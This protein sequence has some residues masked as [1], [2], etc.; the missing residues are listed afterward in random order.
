MNSDSMITTDDESETTSHKNSSENFFS[1]NIKEDSVNYE[2]D[3]TKYTGF[4]F[5][6]EDQKEKRPGIIVV[7][8]WWG[9]NNYIRMRA[10]EL[11]KLGYITLAA[12]VYGNGKTGNDPESAQAL[13]TPFYNDPSL[14]KIRLDPAINFLKSYAQTDPSSIA[15]IGYCF[16][17][18]VVLNA[19]KLGSD[20]KGVVTFHGGLS[21]VMPPKHL[22]TKFLICHGAD[23]EFE[24]PHVEE[25]RKEMDSSN[26]DYNFRVYPNSTHAFTNKDSTE[27][28]QK[29]HMPISYNAAADRDSWEDMKKFLRNLF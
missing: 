3:G 13:A 16:G 11:A 7:H 25:F 4:V 1:G 5:Y 15:A 12:D 19:A 9:L 27:K 18:F 2:I 24:N 20:L 6:K 17:G 23:D 21:G 28:G 29:Y 26:I 10:R 22:K 14:T 8:E